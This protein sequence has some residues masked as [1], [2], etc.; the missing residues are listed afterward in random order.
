[1]FGNKVWPAVLGVLLSPLPS[2][3]TENLGAHFRDPAEFRQIID[4]RCLGCHDRERIEEAMR[5]REAI[6]PLTR[7]MVERGA[8]LTDRDRE[9]LGIFWGMPLKNGEAPTG[10]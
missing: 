2:P 7:R 9:V 6:E 3:G 1:M 8:Q 5:R 4:T 10:E